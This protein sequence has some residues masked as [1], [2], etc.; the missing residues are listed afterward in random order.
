MLL[1]ILTELYFDNRVQVIPPGA[2]S[3]FGYLAE[4]EK[5]LKEPGLMELKEINIVSIVA[6]AEKV[7]IL[8][9]EKERDDQLGLIIK[10]LEK[11]LPGDMGKRYK[12]AFFHIIGDQEMTLFEVNEVTFPHC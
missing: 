9:L 5:R 8:A 6:D 1:K 7:T 12:S 4:L 10:D 3:F 2:I 11:Q